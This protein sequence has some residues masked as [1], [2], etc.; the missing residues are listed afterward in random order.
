M[1]SAAKAYSSSFCRRFAS[2]GSI[3]DLDRILGKM[4]CLAGRSFRGAHSLP[5][6]ARWSYAVSGELAE[7]IGKRLI[8]S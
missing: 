7:Q 3:T 6:R 2:N 1:G 4:G 5:G 8:M